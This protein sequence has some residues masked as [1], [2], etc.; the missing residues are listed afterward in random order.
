MA[1]R[2]RSLSAILIYDYMYIYKGKLFRIYKCYVLLYFLT[3][4]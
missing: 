4:F 1:D 3:H 2:E